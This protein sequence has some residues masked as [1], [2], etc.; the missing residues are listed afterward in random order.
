MKRN[1][2]TS[3]ADEYLESIQPVMPAQSNPYFYTALKARMEAERGT[4][5]WNFRLRPSF[6]VGTL[7]IFLLINVLF[8][9]KQAG[10]KNQQT[11]SSTASSLQQFASGYDLWVSSSF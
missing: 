7:S 5:G 1:I 9:V 3:L 6:L 11:T 8:L 4:P 10:K 2:P